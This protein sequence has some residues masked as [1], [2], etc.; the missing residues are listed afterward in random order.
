MPGRQLGHSTAAVSAQLGSIPSS[1]VPLWGSSGQ[2]CAVQCHRT[3]LG[4]ASAHPVPCKGREGGGQS[5]VE[6]TWVI[7]AHILWALRCHPG[8]VA[9]PADGV[10]RS[11]PQQLQSPPGIPVPS[12]SRPVHHQAV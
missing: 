7:K 10:Y 3:R 9:G 2:H 8:L 1:P 4:F 11:S 5:S 12:A 6:L